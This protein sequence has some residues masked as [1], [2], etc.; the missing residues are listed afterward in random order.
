MLKKVGV[1]AVLCVLAL[2]GCTQKQ[3]AIGTFYM[4][5]RSVLEG[6]FVHWGWDWDDTHPVVRDSFTIY[7]RYNAGPDE[8]MVD[9]TRSIVG[10]IPSTPKPV[11][12]FKLCF[13]DFTGGT[14]ADAD[15]NL[16]RN[17]AIVDSVYKIVVTDRGYQLIIGNALPVPSGSI[18]QYIVWSQTQYNSYLSTLHTQHPNQVFVFDFY[19]VL[20][21]T[22]GAIKNEYTDGEPDDAHLNEAGYNAIDTP[23]FNFLETNF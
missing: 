6:W 9:T 2:G 23:F 15:A 11:I 18:D 12:F 22:N 3:S 7:H 19:S 17:K 21:G 4:L 1:V 14:Q 13:V 10:H 16:S 5:G 20:A 8:G